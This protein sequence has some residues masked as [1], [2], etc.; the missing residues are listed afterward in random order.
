MSSSE[1]R[2]TREGRHRKRGTC[3]ERERGGESRQDIRNAQSKGDARWR[4]EEPGTANSSL[5][6]VF[7]ELVAKGIGVSGLF[8]K[9]RKGVRKRARLGKKNVIIIN[10]WSG[11]V[12]GGKS[13]QPGRRRAE[14]S[15]K[16]S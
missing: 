5:E 11:W 16:E 2:R 7:R 6:E 12:I 14:K 13:R 15:D 3:S 4:I 1:E 10:S 8:G 9:N